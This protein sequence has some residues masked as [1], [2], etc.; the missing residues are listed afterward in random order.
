[1]LYDT[2]MQNMV[3]SITPTDEKLVSKGINS[4][5]QHIT[6]LK[7]HI[8]LSLD[9]FKTFV[10]ENLCS[11]SICLSQQDIE[12]VEEI[13]KEYLSADFIYGNNPSYNI[14]RKGRIEGVGD[15]E[16]RMEL[17]NGII[18]QMNIMGDY[19]LLGDIGEQ[20]IKP[21]I[22]ARLEHDDICRAL[23]DDTGR[24]IM[25]LEKEDFVNLL[26]GN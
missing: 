2:N 15:M 10:K 21:L 9:D 17:K 22:G 13:E 20:I 24:V 12:G 5:R 18:K 23:P 26:C 16:V 8:S 11:E 4:V 1:M 14:T 25:H 6:L 7:D 19:F 3:G